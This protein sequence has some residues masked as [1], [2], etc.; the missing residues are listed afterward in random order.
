M[1]HISSSLY[2]QFPRMTEMEFY[3]ASVL[4]KSSYNDTGSQTRHL[5]ELALAAVKASCLLGFDDTSFVHLRGY[6]YVG[7]CRSSQVGAGLPTFSGLSRESW[8]CWKVNHHPS[9]KVH[10]PD[11]LS[12]RNVSGFR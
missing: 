7:V 11:G 9:L 5:C 8:Y 2:M 3:R 6:S 1:T 4:K 10:T 12:P